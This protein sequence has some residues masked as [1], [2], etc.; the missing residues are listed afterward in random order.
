MKDSRTSSLAGACCLTGPELLFLFSWWLRRAIVGDARHR[1]SPE[2]E[3][4]FEVVATIFRQKK[5]GK[6]E[7]GSPISVSPRVAA[8]SCLRR[9]S[10]WRFLVAIGVHII[11]RCY[12]SPSSSLMLAGEKRGTEMRGL[13]SSLISRSPKKE[14]RG[15]ERGKKGKK[16]GFEGILIKIGKR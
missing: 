10:G 13:A 5:E 11:G 14:M 9:P 15:R 6:R 4:L 8:V 12:C 2:S 3:L 1:C 7:R 16:L